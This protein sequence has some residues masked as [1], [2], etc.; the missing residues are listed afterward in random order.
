[1]KEVSKQIKFMSRRELKKFFNI[2]QIGAWILIAVGIALGFFMYFSTFMPGNPWRKIFYV[3]AFAIISL[4]MYII[5]F[6]D[7]GKKRLNKR[8]V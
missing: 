3:V 6:A 1:M 2:C 7:R 8:R 5:D 4:A